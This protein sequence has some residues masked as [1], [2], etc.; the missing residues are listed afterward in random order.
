MD[1]NN[2]I[3]TKNL[4]NFPSYLQRRN[5]L[6]L[7]VTNQNLPEHTERIS[8]KMPVIMPAFCFDILYEIYSRVKN[9]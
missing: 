8:E 2:K 7:V 3:R 4:L 9:N 5:L 1:P 6:L